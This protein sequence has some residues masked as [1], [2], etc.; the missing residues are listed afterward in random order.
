LDGGAGDDW[1]VGNAGTDSLI[2]GLGSDNYR[3]SR[4]DGADR[5]NNAATDY[6]TA[7]DRLVLG[8][9]VARN[10]VWLQRSGED[11][12]VS[13]MGTTDSS[14]V[15]GWYSA[16][17]TSRLDSF[18]AGDGRVMTEA[19]VEALVQAM[20][21]MAPPSVGQTNLTTEQQT[22]LNTTIAAAWQ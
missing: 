5:L 14:R 19:R 12:L 2:G 16:N 11:L 20:A 22:A 7:T 4:G 13:I 10:Q 17:T 1:L 21:T 3:L 6:L 18:V 9:D 8:A 15:L